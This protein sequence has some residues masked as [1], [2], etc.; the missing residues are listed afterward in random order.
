MHWK[1]LSNL[2]PEFAKNNQSIG[3]VENF[4]SIVLNSGDKNPLKTAGA[5][6]RPKLERSQVC[7]SALFRR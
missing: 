2:I 6:L 3:G 5:A 7:H 4:K 1:A